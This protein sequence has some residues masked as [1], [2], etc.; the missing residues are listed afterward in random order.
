MSSLNIQ[1]P[2]I[3]NTRVPGF[4][5]EINT[6]NALPG[7]APTPDSLILIAQMT[8]AGSVAANLPQKVFSDA[9]AALYFGQGSVAHLASRA[10]LEANPNI[11]LSVVG[12][13]DNGSTKATGSVVIS[14]ACT[15]IPGAVDLWIGDEHVSTGVSVG[16][17]TSTIAGRLKT[18]LD[19]I[20][21]YLPV[22]YTLSSG[23]LAFTARNAGTLG[24]TTTITAINSSDATS[25]VT[26][27]ASGSTDPDVGAY[28]TT[29]S[30]LGSIVGGNYTIVI[31]TLADSGNLTKI[32]TMNT[33]V[34]NPNN[35]G[36]QIT[37]YG[38]T[39]QIGT[40]ANAETLAGTMNSGTMTEGYVNYASGNLAK[41]EPYKIGARYAAVLASTSD[42]VV[43]YDGLVVAQDA[44]AVPDRFTWT[45]KQDLLSN[46]V[47]P[48]AVVP[49][50]ELAIVR[51]ISTYTLN[52]QG[53]PDPTLLDINTMRTMFFVRSQVRTRLTNV[54][55]GAKLNARTMRLMKPEVL[56]V[57]YNLQN[58]E[59]V[60]NVAKY[61]S[62]V[63][64][65]QDLSDVTRVDIS[66]PTNIISGLHVI[67]S[68]FNLILGV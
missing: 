6:N 38:Y 29:S 22:T 13:A 4:Y 60:Q 27:M 44:P 47:T 7:L 9:D 24:N 30:V 54:F 63:L 31:S 65:E 66:V 26:D 1:T 52:S 23:T 21:T 56:D 55:R 11:A 51:A 34:N 46:G 14:S 32:K 39:D 59:I 40:F 17:S 18:A 37:V 49:G 43:P 19:Q 28:D 58:A 64:V 33:F 67:G 48:L 2:F 20:Q 12:V 25:V 53:A 36:N 45:Q 68:V 15:V 61:E 41:P 8:S 5:G 35:N 50:D 10:A 62:A 57:L 42:P 3:P 16:D